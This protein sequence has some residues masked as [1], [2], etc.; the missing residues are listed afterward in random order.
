V[1]SDPQ[2]DAL[3]DRIAPRAADARDPA[4]L[5]PDI[6]L[7]GAEDRID[8][9]D[10]RYDGIELG[11]AG[12]TLGHPR[13]QR[14]GVAPDRLVAGRLEIRLDADP[15]VRVGQPHAVFDGGSVARESFLRR[16]TAHRSTR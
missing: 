9:E 2:V 4:V 1:R 14:L 10:A 11:R 7:D 3:G 12:G 15:Q 5:D 13:S 6:G 16:Q 8:D